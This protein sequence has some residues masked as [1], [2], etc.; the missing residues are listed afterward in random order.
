MPDKKRSKADMER[1]RIS[2]RS[3]KIWDENGVLVAEMLE[4]K[5]IKMPKELEKK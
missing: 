2:N 3:F 5:W 4:G 1:R